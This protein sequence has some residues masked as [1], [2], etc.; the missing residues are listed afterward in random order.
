MKCCLMRAIRLTTSWQ[1]ARL[2]LVPGSSSGPLPDPPTP[3]LSAL[4]RTSTAAFPVSAYG[5]GQHSSELCR[6]RA[7]GDSQVV[8]CAVSAVTSGFPTS[9]L[10]KISRASFWAPP[11]PLAAFT[12]DLTHLGLGHHTSVTGVGGCSRTRYV[13][14]SKQAG[15][16]ANE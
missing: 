8:P 12:K 7:Y 15:L 13:V 11:T 16:G 14:R 4:P 3:G 5:S 6:W 1:K 2:N 9:A 10:S